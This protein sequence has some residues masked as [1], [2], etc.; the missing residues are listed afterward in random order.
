MAADLHIHILEGVDESDLREFFRNTLGS[1]YFGVVP[2]K[3]DPAIIDKIF[4]T[5]AVWVGEVSWLKAAL[6]AGGG[7]E[8]VPGPVKQ[9]SEIVGEDLP[10]IDDALIARIESA[11]KSANHTSYSVAEASKVVEF[12]RKHI[13]KRAF[14][15]SW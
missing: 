3:R 13:G 1:K 4:S 2:S 6:F 7:S 10:I 11:M 15:V 14:C 9:V 12:L 8:Y 5:P